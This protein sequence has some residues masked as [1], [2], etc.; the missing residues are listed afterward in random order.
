MFSILIGFNLSNFQLF[1]Y[2]MGPRFPHLGSI[3]GQLD[4]C[5]VGHLG[6]QEIGE[7]SF[8]SMIL[9]LCKLIRFKAK[10]WQ[11]QRGCF[12][13]VLSFLVSF[14]NVTIPWWPKLATVTITMESNNNFQK[15]ISS[16]K[17]FIIVDVTSCEW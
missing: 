8:L 16:K 10:K 3:D 17:H 9:G 13:I 15:N 5:T 4:L 11:T 2:M 6:T 7:S 12:N 1:I 14:S